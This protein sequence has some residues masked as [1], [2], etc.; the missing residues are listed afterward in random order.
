M[1]F[2]EQ[3]RQA[4]DAGHRLKPEYDKWCEEERVLAEQRRVAAEK[5]RTERAKLRLKWLPDRVRQAA[6]KGE[7]DC[8]AV[9]VRVEDI[10]GWRSMVVGMPIDSR[11]LKEDSLR[12]FDLLEADGLSPRLIKGTDGMFYITIP[13]PPPSEGQP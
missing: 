10:E 8:I 2:K 5:A 7:P 12:I 3:V 6:R 4:A 11:S 1:T 9:M 13:I